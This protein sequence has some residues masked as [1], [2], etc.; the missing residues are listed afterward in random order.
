MGKIIVKY[1]L[2]F[3]IL[4]KKVNENSQLKKGILKK[5]EKNIYK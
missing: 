3:F 2:N 4:P 1:T 5:N